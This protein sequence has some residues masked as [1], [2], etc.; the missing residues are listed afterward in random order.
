MHIDQFPCVEVPGVP[1]AEGSYGLVSK[2]T[3]PRTG[4]VVAIKQLRKLY[5]DKKRNAVLK[6]L[7]MLERCDHP[8]IIRLLVAYQLEDDPS[9]I[10]LVTEPWAPYTLD[11]FLHEGDSRRQA[12]CPW[13]VQGSADTEGQILKIFKGLAAG[14]E[15][16][17]DNSIKHKDIKPPNILLHNPSGD[18]LRPIIADLGISKIFQVGGSTDYNQST[19]TYLA[20]EQ[21]ASIESSLKADI[22]QMGC[23][24]ALTLTVFHAGSAGCRQLWNS[25]ENTN[26]DCSCN[27]AKESIPFMKTL[28]NLCGSGTP[29]QF[30]VYRLITT[31]LDINPASRP[32][33]GKIRRELEKLN[34]RITVS[35]FS[36][37]YGVGGWLLKI[38]QSK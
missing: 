35:F 20:P 3:N 25:F 9:I 31:M 4:A 11:S 19:Y 22:W 12:A 29:S 23:C 14:L 24:F 8:N 37:T 1:T 38:M 33:V 17:H 27:I 10:Y 13:F 21:I 18:N 28:N 16:L 34:W 7:G 5:S 36:Y 6:E 26:E 2:A 30:Q 15:Y 32:D